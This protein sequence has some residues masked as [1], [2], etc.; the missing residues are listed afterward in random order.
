MRDHTRILALLITVCVTLHTAPN[1]DAKTPPA[2]TLIEAEDAPNANQYGNVIDDADASGGQAVT[3]PQEWRPLF[4][5]ALPNGLPDRVTVHVR[6]KGG[7]IQLKARVDG[8]NQPLKWAWSKPDRYA[9]V[10]LGTYDRDKL[11]QSIEII[12]G[13]ADQPPRIDAVVLADASATASG[14][15]DPVKTP[16]TGTDTNVPQSAQDAGITGDA[17]AGANALPPAAPRPDLTPIDVPITVDW[18]TTLGPITPAHWGVALFSVADPVK[19]DD[20]G[21]V[22]FLTTLRPGLVRVHHSG[23][24]DRWSNAQTRDW[25][26]QAIAGSLAPLRHLPDATLM[27]NLPNWPEWFSESKAISP[28]QYSEAEDLV[29]RWVRAV[30]QAS[31]VP[32]THFEVF[33]EFDNTWDKAGRINELWPLFHSMARAVKE[34]APDAK[35][36]GPS[37]TW[38]NGEWVRPFLD[39]AGG[40]I[41][42]IS[43]HNYAAGKPTTPNDA[44]LAR[45]EAVDRH[46]GDV[47]RWLTER[48]LGHIETHLNEYNVQWTWKPYE[49]RHANAI[50][51]ALHASIIGR[52]AERGITG[53]AVWHA[54]GNA[55]GLIDESNRLR[56]TG[57]LF[58]LG[59]DHLVGQ[60]APTTGDSDQPV[61]AFAV[62]TANGHRSLL[63]VNRGEAP[64]RV[65]KPAELLDRSTPPVMGVLHRIDANGWTAEPLKTRQGHEITLPGWSVTIISTQPNHSRWGTIILPGQEARFDF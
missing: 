61:D 36:G 23:L 1:A 25:D 57:Q 19:A 26:T 47:Q 58:L 3:S 49:R 44:V 31:P 27:V 37:F 20:P 7:P 18:S 9:W 2:G 38:A 22:G 8:K 16:S 34:E 56:A 14:P 46:A 43:W 4:R 24:A 48:G 13:K 51:A 6:R 17:A 60:L 55:Y 59:R 52:L 64:A 10:S 33:N 35:V 21:F 63:L 28:D 41:D 32:V 45:A 40:T 65:G 50:G 15:A 54:K 39:E 53:L 11:G 42:F 12:R 5:Y 29:R 62:N 30:K